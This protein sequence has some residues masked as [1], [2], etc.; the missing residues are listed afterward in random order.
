M[1]EAE[2]GLV[3]IRSSERREWCCFD[4][5]YA[6]A[7]FEL[8]GRIGFGTSDGRLVFPDKD[9]DADDG[10]PITAIYRSQFVAFSNPE[11]PKRAYRMTLCADTG[12]ATLTVTAETD[13]HRRTFW[14]IGQASDKPE[15]FDFRVADGRFRFLRYRI[16]VTGKVRT[17]IYRLSVFAN[18]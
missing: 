15:Y 18:P 1:W 7:F 8:D 10:Q 6:T 3:W 9:A 14:A 5:I 16:E 4:N 12:G 17:R 13:A 2:E 11:V